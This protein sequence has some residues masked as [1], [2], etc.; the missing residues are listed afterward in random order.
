MVAPM[1]AIA[2]VLVGGWILALL[3]DGTWTYFANESDPDE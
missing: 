3:I 2:A 1:L